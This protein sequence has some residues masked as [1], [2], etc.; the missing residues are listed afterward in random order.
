MEKLK[1][2]Y[3]PGYPIRGELFGVVLLF[4]MAFIFSHQFLIRLW[5]MTWDLYVHEGKE[6]FLKPDAVAESFS[7]M[8]EGHWWYFLAP[9]YYLAVMAVGHYLYY[10]QKTKSIY[11]MRRIPKRGV[12]FA[13]CV[14]G[15]AFWTVVLV[16]GTALLYGLYFVLYWLVVPAECMPRLV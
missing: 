1:R 3:P 2:L 14:K 15:A 13:S 5:N 4:G 16:L 7:Q 11:V 12:V 8:V 10:W 9:L 6:R